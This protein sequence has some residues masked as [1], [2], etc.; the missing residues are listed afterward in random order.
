VYESKDL[1]TNANNH[2]GRQKDFELRKRFVY[3]P[4]LQPACLTVKLLLV[5]ASTVILASKRHVTHYLILL[6]DVSGTIQK[7]TGPR[8]ERYR[9]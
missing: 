1:E 2:H 8:G 6:S 9:M 3:L 7:K 4:H 5:L